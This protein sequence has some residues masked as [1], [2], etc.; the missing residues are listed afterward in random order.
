MLNKTNLPT[1]FWDEA[2]SMACYV[3]NCVLVRHFLKKT[4]YELYK[5]RKPNIAYFHIFGYK[6]FVLNNAK[7]NLGKFNAKFDGCIFFGYSRIKE[8]LL[9]KNLLMYLLMK[10]TPP[11][12]KKLFN[13]MKMMQIFH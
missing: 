13:F 4:P 9:S 2:V 6:C 3:S 10:L 5:G 12:R 1:Y 8:F 7:D 11:R